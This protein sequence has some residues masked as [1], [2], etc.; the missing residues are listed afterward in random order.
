MDPT[1]SFLNI[2]GEMGMEVPLLSIVASFLKILNIYV[3]KYRTH[4]KLPKK[5]DGQL[6]QHIL[7]SLI[8]SFGAI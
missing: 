2:H 5:I 3:A 7:Y 1:I 4:K 6:N 8:W